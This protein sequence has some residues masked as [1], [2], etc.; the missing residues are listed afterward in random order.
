MTQSCII[1][2]SWAGTQLYQML[3]NRMEQR[4]RYF[5]DEISLKLFDFEFRKIILGGPNLIRLK[6]LKKQLVVFLKS[7]THCF[8]GLKE[9]SHY[10]FHN[11]KEV[12]YFSNLRLQLMLPLSNFPSTDPHLAFGYKSPFV[13][14]ILRIGSMS[15]IR[16]LFLY[17]KSPK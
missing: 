9:I 14:A 4:W 15:T 13:H 11:H 2:S 5:A 12:N 8:A 6:P 10:E 7:E 16:S 3:A 1:P 17:C